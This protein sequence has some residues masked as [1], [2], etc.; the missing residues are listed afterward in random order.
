MGEAHYEIINVICQ[1]I[2]VAVKHAINPTTAARQSK[3]VANNYKQR[4]W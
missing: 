1:A 2:R 3:F 4:Y